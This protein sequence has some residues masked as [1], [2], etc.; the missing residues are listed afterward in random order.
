[1][2]EVYSVISEDYSLQNGDF[3][4]PLEYA[5]KKGKKV[6]SPEEGVVKQ[7]NTSYCKN[8]VL[9]QHTIQSKKFYTLFCNVERVGVDYGDNIRKGSEIGIASENTTVNLLD[10]S[11]G[12]VKFKN[13][14]RFKDI[15]K[16]K[17]ITGDDKFKIK[18][19][20][21]LDLALKP[22]E[23][24]LNFPEM[25]TSSEADT[26]EPYKWIKWVQKNTTSKN[27]SVQ[28]NITKIKKLL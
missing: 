26:I 23:K 14:T 2:K 25:K 20:P 7:I 28:R 3:T 27:E 17:G 13:V 18:N 12:K 6:L 10:S 11:K 24:V 22:L 1:M 21:L 15:E 4:T 16:E 8:S 9:L 5:V 19:D